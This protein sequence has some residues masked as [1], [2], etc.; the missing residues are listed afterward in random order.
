[1]GREG[2]TQGRWGGRFWGTCRVHLSR[3]LTPFFGGD[4][5]IQCVLQDSS[6]LESSGSPEPKRPGGPEAA[7]GSQEKLDFNRNL[8]EGLMSAL[9]RDIG[10]W[11]GRWWDGGSSFLWYLSVVPAIEKLLSSD[12]KERFLG[13]SSVEAKDVKGEGH[14]QR[15]GRRGE[16]FVPLSLLQA[17]PCSLG[18]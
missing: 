13:R 10:A 3:G 11:V 14:G 4:S 18:L 12:W 8:K 5:D 17:W 9:F 16:M 7:S 15:R 6:S 2:L 1:M